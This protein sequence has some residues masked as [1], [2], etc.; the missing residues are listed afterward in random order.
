MAAAFPNGKM[1]KAENV[2]QLMATFDFI[3]RADDGDEPGRKAQKK[4]TPNWDRT[5]LAVG[6]NFSCISYLKVEKIEGVKITVRNQ[7]GGAWIM[8]KAI[9]ERDSY[10]GDHF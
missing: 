9:L 3:L 1:V 4:G 2:S 8:S 10:S 6:D 5:K 7:L